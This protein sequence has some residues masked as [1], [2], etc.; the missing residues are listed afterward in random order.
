MAH[1]LSVKN[2]DLSGLAYR[3]NQLI[4]VAAGEDSDEVAAPVSSWSPSMIE[5]EAVR[6]EPT[7]T[8]PTAPKEPIDDPQ[9]AASLAAQPVDEYLERLFEEYKVAKASIGDDASQMAES[10]FKERLL[11]SGAGIAEQFEVREVRFIVEL[12]GGRVLLRPVLIR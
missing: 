8:R 10:R 2:D 5:S 1:R 6:R 9:L 11:A 7:P 12:D 3:I 4:G